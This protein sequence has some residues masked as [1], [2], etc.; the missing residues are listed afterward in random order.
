MRYW[1]KKKG[2]PLLMNVHEVLKA[3]IIQLLAL[4]TYLTWVN[5]LIFIS[6][7]LDVISYKVTIILN[8]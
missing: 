2:Q 3:K 8:K 1:K 6:A 4:Y 7:V 5:N